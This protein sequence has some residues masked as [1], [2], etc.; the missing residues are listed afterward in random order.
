MVEYSTWWTVA[1][2]ETICLG[3]RK[4]FSIKA[5][6]SVFWM[7]VNLCLKTFLLI[8]HF[9]IE[10]GKSRGF[11]LSSHGLYHSLT[12]RK[13]GKK[14]TISFHLG[15][16]TFLTNVYSIVLNMHSYR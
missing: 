16:L 12:L 5:E 7:K 9:R 8:Y 4:L 6:E 13:K 15:T 11:F 1:R 14:E 10:K 2:Q 3:N